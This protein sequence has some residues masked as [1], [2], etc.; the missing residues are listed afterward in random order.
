[1]SYTLILCNINVHEYLHRL[2]NYLHSDTPSPAAAPSH[3]AVIWY[4]TS[5]QMLTA[6]LSHQSSRTIWKTGSSYTIHSRFTWKTTS[7][8]L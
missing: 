4:G 2:Y 7:L 6:L 5:C 3:T 8:T 1:M